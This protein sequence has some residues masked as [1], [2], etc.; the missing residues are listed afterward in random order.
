MMQ[1]DVADTTETHNLLMVKN[2]SSD[3]ADVSDA[4]GLVHKKVFVFCCADSN[5]ISR[6]PTESRKMVALSPA[7]RTRGGARARLTLHSDSY[8]ARESL[9]QHC[10]GGRPARK[11]GRVNGF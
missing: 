11:G 3:R 6:S 5:C 8:V 7:R 4:T 10:R 9:R 1:A 2:P